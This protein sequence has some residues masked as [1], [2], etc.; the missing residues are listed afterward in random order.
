ME[1]TKKRLEAFSKE[2]EDLVLKIAAKAKDFRRYPHYETGDKFDKAAIYC[3]AARTK[4]FKA[5]E[6]LC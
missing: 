2:L 6:S 1:E 4:L 3:Q 5:R